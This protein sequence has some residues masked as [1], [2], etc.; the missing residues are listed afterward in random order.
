ML[1]LLLFTYSKERVRRVITAFAVDADISLILLP[2]LR[3]RERYAFH[4]LCH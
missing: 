2:P 4:Y 3:R 1:G